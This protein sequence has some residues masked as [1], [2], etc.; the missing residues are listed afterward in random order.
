M[1]YVALDWS[2]ALP[3]ELGGLA[4]G[5]RM[6]FVLNDPAF[7]VSHR[8]ILG[9][10]A[11][12]AGFRVGVVS[13]GGFGEEAIRE[14]GFD[15]I[16][17]PMSRWGMN[18]LDEV[19]VVRALRAIYERERPRLVHH[20]T[21]KAVLYGS[22]AAGQARVPAVVNA[23]SGLGFLFVTRGP[24]AYLRRELVK[25]L[26][27]RALRLPN[28]HLILQNRDDLELLAGGRIAPRSGMSMIRGSGVNVNQFLPNPPR[29]RTPLVLFASRL[30]REKGVAEF[31][32][33]ARILKSQGVA[34][35][36]VVAGAPIDGHPLSVSRETLAE[37]MREGCVEIWGERSDMPR[38]ISQA[39]IVCLPTYYGE[40]TPKILIEAAA[41][42]KPIVTTDMPGCREIVRDGVNGLLV[43][44]RDPEATASAIGRL[45]SDPALGAEMGFKGRRRVIQDGY[46]DADVV[47]ETLT[48]YRGLLS[49]AAG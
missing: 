15:H 24:R 45:I 4:A 33:A 28:H 21:V 49:R 12:Q 42:G 35:R 32:A 10:A 9:E 47:R 16:R 11:R 1:V 39:H 22:L 3:S 34:A 14:A 46:T 13:P 38:V 17:L 48:I 18:P 19:K 36:F 37:W 30:L 6:L 8:M 31:V 20:V 25:L 44:P 29:D 23:L 26:L 27:R 43:P 7:F 41:C 2:G 40:G 5:E